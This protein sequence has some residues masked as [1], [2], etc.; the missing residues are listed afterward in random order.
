LDLN[1]REF[2]RLY[3]GHRESSHEPK[4]ERLQ[5][6]TAQKLEAQTT[7][8]IEESKKKLN[9]DVCLSATQDFQ[10]KP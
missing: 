3:E 7:E 2:S 9:V 4:K 8:K 5:G 1:Q 10:E 6:R